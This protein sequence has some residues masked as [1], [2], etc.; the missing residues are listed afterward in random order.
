MKNVVYILKSLKNDRYYIGSTNDLTRRFS[1]HTNGRSKYTKN[2]LP[3]ELLFSQE[4]DTLTDA[5]KMERRLKNFK[6]K[7]I[8]ERIIRDKKIKLGP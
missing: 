3:L 5:R 1:E 4:F 6:N 7:E 8:I 2:V